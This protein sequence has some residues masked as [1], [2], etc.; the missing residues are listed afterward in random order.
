MDV[1]NFITVNLV[2]YIKDILAVYACKITTKKLIL[3]QCLTQMM[4]RSSGSGGP[5]RSES[6]VEIGCLWNSGNAGC[7]S[8]THTLKERERPLSTASCTAA[9]IFHTPTFKEGG[10]QRDR[11]V[12]GPW[13]SIAQRGFSLAQQTILSICLRKCLTSYTYR[14]LTSAFLQLYDA[15]T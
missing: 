7:L 6:F 13:K 8:N 15:R 10:G 12:E 9:L 4:C 2:I 11:A 14:S 1:N 5:S 3:D